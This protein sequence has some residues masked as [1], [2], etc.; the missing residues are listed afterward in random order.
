[1]GNE[2]GEEGSSHLLSYGAPVLGA[3]EAHDVPEGLVE[4]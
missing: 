1:M 2:G 3:H 4:T